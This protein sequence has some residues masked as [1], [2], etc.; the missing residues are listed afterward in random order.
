VSR[1]SLPAEP[2]IFGRDGHESLSSLFGRDVTLATPEVTGAT[3]SISGNVTS[4]GGRSLAGICAVAVTPGGRGYQSPTGA[5]GSYE[6]KG[7]AAGGYYVVFA[8]A[9]GNEAGWLGTSYANRSLV[10]VRAGQ[11]VTN[12]D[13]H[14]QQG[15]SISGT[16][17]NQLGVALKRIC[18]A[19]IS[20]TPNSLFIAE[21]LG[22][23]RGGTYDFTGLPAGPWTVTFEGCGQNVAPQW[24]NDQSQFQHA[25]VI[26][27]VT[28]KPA[29]G[30]DGVLAA[31]G[32]ISG[33]V[34]SPSGKGLAGICAGV[35][36]QVQKEVTFTIS[37]ASGPNGNYSIRALGT[38]TYKPQFAAGCPSEANYAP[39]TDPAKVG[40][41]AGMPTTGADV[42][43]VPGATI[44]GTV[45]GRHGHGIAGIC[46]E[47]GSTNPSALSLI[48][49]V[50]TMSN[51]NY[52]FS[53]LPAGG[54]ELEFTPGCPNEGNY[55][56]QFYDNQISSADA[57]VVSV[58]TGGSA[59]GIDASMQVG[60][61]ISGI[62][63]DAGGHPV[64][65]ACIEALPVSGAFVDEVQAFLTGAYEI[66]GLPTDA[67]VVYFDPTCGGEQPS[68]SAAIYYPGADRVSVTAGRTTADIDVSL[69]AGGAIAG[70]VKSVPAEMFG[71]LYLLGPTGGLREQI[72]LQL[73][74]N[75]SYDVQ[76]IL[77]GS[78]DIAASSCA[79][80]AKTAP[81][82]YPNRQSLQG[83]RPITVT[84]GTRLSRID[85]DLPR[86][87]RITG[88]VSRPDGTPA[89][90]CI[91]AVNRSPG[92]SVDDTIAVTDRKGDYV[93]SGIGTGTY[94]LEFGV[95]G[96][97]SGD[98]A[99]RSAP[100]RVTDGTKVAG[101]D[102]TLT[103]AG[104]V[105]GEVT[106]TTGAALGGVCVEALGG[107]GSETVTASNGTYYLGGLPAGRVTI[108]FFSG[109]GIDGTW[110]GTRTGSIRVVSG[111]LTAGVNAKLAQGGS[112]AGAVTVSAG[113]A[114]EIC[115]I[116]VG[117]NATEPTEV[118]TTRN[119]G[120]YSFA[121]LDA[122][123]YDVEF[124]NGCGNATEYATQW[125]D[126]AS[127]QADATGVAV[128]SGSVASGIDAELTV[129]S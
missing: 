120:S 30:I 64:D 38:G 89:S 37:Y 126:D 66:D 108:A 91:F 61:T 32:T 68:S 33:R 117:T 128:P 96:E 107:S 40:V 35:T 3:G 115:V 56:T 43:M 21:E 121:G 125:W 122:G 54:Y 88:H 65:G 36:I 111:E 116:A 10:G 48:F 47:I 112:I 102:A 17:K 109:C 106:S 90:A 9:C 75:G 20:V 73:P 103:T 2:V 97:P 19:A 52:F 5:S 114:H 85:F 110:S 12:I 18:V 8:P 86:T 113:S 31:G 95:C 105:A 15:S 99:V 59:P 16:V 45:T 119:D 23:G 87:A 127:S 92:G 62:V 93:M 123:T 7:L 1:V 80:G 22:L 63:T 70:K 78:Y 82:F 4:V 28:G 124:T 72:F 67:Y 77:P 46:V 71:C 44:S 81:D 49:P 34:T 129:A 57:A 84:A 24:W 26:H 29:T 76:G 27:L 104:F 100:V 25:T 13:G 94:V 60:G 98:A 55:I 83:A 39:T 74:P 101:V 41:V 79:V 14:L 53:Q 69:P 58:A 11:D 50:A 51:G 118:A 42:T 6:I